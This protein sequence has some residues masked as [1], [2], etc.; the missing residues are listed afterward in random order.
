MSLKDHEYYR[1]DLG[2]LYHADCLSIMPELEPVDLV[3]TDPP[4]GKTQNKWDIIIPFKDM[5][6]VCNLITNDETAI[7]ITATN[8]FA[9]ELICSNI[10]MFRYDIVW[11]K[12]GKATGFLNSNRMPLRNHELVLVFYKK[13]PKYNPQKTKGNPNHPKFAKGSHSRGRKQTNRNYGEFD[14]SHQSKPT[15]DKFPLSVQD[16]PVV[17]PPIHPTQKSLQLFEWLIKTY[18]DE[19]DTV[20][21]FTIGSGTTAIACER[22]NRRWIGIEIEEKYCEIAAKRIEKEAKQLKLFK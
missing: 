14:Q 8:P 6:Q 9:A 1:T 13:L 2:V 22:L 18:T 19:G 4:Y 15:T 5:W 7:I 12:V 17:H 20:L 21:D 16:F 11:R 3:L 10:R